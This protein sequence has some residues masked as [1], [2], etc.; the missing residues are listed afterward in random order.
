MTIQ[1]EL[2]GHSLAVFILVLCA[3]CSTPIKSEFKLHSFP[4][5][6]AFVEKPTRPFEI[7]GSVKTKVNFSTLETEDFR[8]SERTLCRNYFNKA[9]KDLVH[10]AK[11]NGGDAVIQIR[12]VTFL[13]TGQV[14]TFS[15]PECSDDGAEGQI[16]LTGIV[17][18]WK[19]EVGQDAR[20]GNDAPISHALSGGEIYPSLESD[21]R[22]EDRLPTSAASPK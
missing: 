11:K 5:N 2:L 9:A 14:E 17:V 3:S 4:K 1:H 22:L 10:L 20:P 21:T 7:L 8:G 19:K 15:T 6:K 18:K 13:E 16:L 12:S